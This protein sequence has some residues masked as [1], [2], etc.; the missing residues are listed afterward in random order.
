[1]NQRSDLYCKKTAEMSEIENLKLA[2]ARER[3]ARKEA[4]QIVEEKSAE[5]YESNQ[6]LL[7]LNRNLEQEIARRTQEIKILALFPE[8]IPDPVLRLS[9]TGQI[10]YANPASQNSLLNYFGL[11]IGDP[12]PALFKASVEKALATGAPVSQEYVIDHLHYLI[13][14]SGLKELKY[15]NILARDITEIKNAQEQ[16]KQSENR[17]RQIIESAS[18]MIYR[19]NLNGRFNYIN[20][21][22]LRML[23]F[24][25]KEILSMDYTDFVHPQYL[26]QVKEF[27]CRQIKH[28]TL[29]TYL[30]FP[31]I[32]QSGEEMWIGQNVQ[33]SDE[34]DKAL[35]LTALARD[36]T[37]RKQAEQALHLTSTRLTTL[38]SSMQTGVMVEDENQKIVLVNEKFCQLFRLE[39]GP[40]E[41][42]GLNSQKS[43][44]KFKTFTQDPEAFERDI[45]GILKSQ[46][47]KTG[48]EIIFKDGRI[49]E[50]DY[51][52]I[53]EN[54][55]FL[56]HLW[57]YR[58][59]T[60][61]KKSEASLLQSQKAL[62]EAQELA[63]LGN[64]ELNLH[65]YEVMWSPQVYQHFELEEGSTPTFKIYLESLHPDDREVSRENFKKCFETGFASFEIRIK[66]KDSQIRYLQIT[67]KTSYGPDKKPVNVYGTCLDITELRKVEEQL[68]ESEERFNLAVQGTNDG[69][70]DWLIEENQFFL[71]PQWKKMLGY[72]PEELKTPLQTW[73]ERLHPSERNTFENELKGF[74]EGSDNLMKTEHRMRHKDGHYLNILSRGL[75][76][77]D[78]NGKPV[79]MVGSNT[80]ITEQK[81][82][83]RNMVRSLKQQKLISDI[84]FLFSSV[85]EDLQDP[86]SQAI[87][88]LG[89]HA[90][91]SRVHIFENSADG[92]FTSNTF[93]WCNNGIRPQTE[94]L[95]NI[96][97]SV[98]PSW[99]RKL[100]RGGLI[101]SNVRDLPE[102][103]RDIL[104]PQDVKS[105]MAFPVFV[106]KK[107][108]GFV[109]F[110]NC[111]EYRDWE[112]TEIQ[113]LK[114]FT[115][116]LGNVFE[117]QHTEQQLLLSEEKYRSVVDNLTE[118]IFQTDEKSFLTFLNPAWTDITGYKLE[119]SLG[120][121]L[122][123]F[124]Y[125]IDR[126]EIDELYELLIDRKIDFCKETL[127]LTTIN[128]EIRWIEVFARVTINQF[129]QIDGIS[130]TLNDVTDRKLAEEGLIQA[131]EQAEQAS[132]A[133]AQFLSTM[134]HEIRTPMNAVIGIT[135]L[136]MKNQPRPDQQ[137]NLSLLKFSGEN[138]LHLLNDILDFSK[139]EA[140]KVSFEEVDF[141]VKDLLS[142]IE[143]SL[144]VKATEKGIELRMVTGSEL[145]D[146]IAG[147]PTRLSQ[148][149]NNLI[150]NAIKFTEEGNVSLSVDLLEQN[151]E[152]YLLRF[153]VTDTGI[154]IS[155]EK[156][157]DI[158]DSFSQASSDTTRKYGG[159]G[160]GLTITKKLLELQGSKIQVESVPN[161]GSRFFF[162]LPF[163]PALSEPEKEYFQPNIKSAQTLKGQ[164]I[165]LVEDNPVNVVVASQ[166]L[167]DWGA[168]IVVA[169]NGAI[170]VETVKSQDF[171]LVLMDLQMP[172]MDGYEATR[173]IREMFSH[174]QMPVIALTADA[175]QGVHELIT[176]AG[177]NDY[178]S[179]P[180]IP[181]ELY[182]KIIKYM[183]PADSPKIPVNTSEEILEVL[184]E[185]GGV[186]IS[187]LKQVKVMEKTPLYKLD[188][189]Y[190]QSG[191]NIVFVKR[192]AGLFLQTTPPILEEI[193]ESMQQKEAEKVHGL[194][195]KLKP[196]V[197]LL[198]IDEKERVRKI[199]K[200]DSAMLASPEGQ[201]EVEEFME[202]MRQV[203]EQMSTDPA[204]TE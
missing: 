136:L 190:E 111:L 29:T 82:V 42:I 154:G 11:Q 77:R 119:D 89:K 174:E 188:K 19:F 1:M 14:F 98:I 129:N 187:E 97:Y 121:N 184:D 12:C 169:E 199:E 6:E 67:V 151:K 91:V 69:I 149:L 202:T 177:M 41:L 102:D 70:W 118:V 96:P 36:I 35:E 166:F 155:E 49:M 168:E 47:I 59:V 61:K 170:A 128:G 20:P 175:M 139:I 43:S 24:T 189:L 144:G 85:V 183:K 86:I 107:F 84:S 21:V 132:Q 101:C 198:D 30:E 17:Y 203:C 161:K 13:Y 197:D 55:H 28:K 16:L 76:V 3:Q 123:D 7:K 173:R 26:D 38:I 83:E 88:M 191:G 146:R 127:R 109:V 124:I 116:L 68:K 200:M 143:Q 18:D 141:N 10:V 32:K 134:S 75:L 113:L 104:E 64:W 164:K 73:L 90:D 112:D 25:E 126:I 105:I 65:T 117:R 176:A 99:R 106:V 51:V 63:R 159:T 31:V 142:G 201:Q 5:L 162:V 23:N 48:E 185:P 81:K 95:E 15:I 33:I 45:K 72:N 78:K 40:D 180:F 93:E 94:N 53:V 2:L 137:K 100:L 60:E 120:M 57:Q 196:S 110:D 103:M 71:S 140:G 194:A 54:N 181:D 195:H 204:V 125:P 122:L 52:P 145:P 114:T 152:G 50:R 182:K 130:G 178:I 153:A 4:E 34:E 165:L 37:D 138:L 62:L 39:K 158:F 172:V 147:D 133:K 135:N 160:L 167:E 9:R 171:C 22:G 66:R 87:E 79:R 156:L 56:G 46:K 179:K 44:A 108:I 115:N 92:V 193:K 74:L 27:Y 192:M 58:D 80:D 150:G 186:I 148:V 131:K 8:E 163:K 157:D